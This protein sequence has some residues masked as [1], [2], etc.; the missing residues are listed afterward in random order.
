MARN[1]IAERRQ[2]YFVTKNAELTLKLGDHFLCAVSA[3]PMS[4]VYA[5]SISPESPHNKEP[6]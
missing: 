3:L 6:P 2:K 4:S 5:L 1:V